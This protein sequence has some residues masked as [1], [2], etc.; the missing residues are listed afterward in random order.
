MNTLL[1]ESEKCDL[2]PRNCRVRRSEGEL[3]YCRSTAD[4]NIAAIC[5]HRGEEPVLSGKDGICNVFFT[6]CNLQCVFCQNYQISRNETNRNGWR[7]KPQEV[8]RKIEEILT[9]GAKTVGFVSPSHCVPQMRTIIHLLKERGNRPVFVMNTNAYDKAGTI[10]GLAD[11]IDVYLPDFKYMVRELADSFSQ[12]PDYPEVAREALR[13]MFRQKG[14][15]IE[16]GPDG[17]IR[18]GLIIRHLVL[19]GQIENSIS[20]LRFIA[21]ELSPCV[22]VSLMAQYHPTPPVS[23]HPLLGRAVTREEYEEVRKELERLGFEKGWLQEPESAGQ[24]L[25][26]FNRPEIFSQPDFD[27][28]P[29]S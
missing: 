12:A 22:H 29:E 2:C 1:A 28:P 26:D 5:L 16:I 7:R 20:C 10:R 15:E 13:E 25:P 19:P 24:Y 27:P 9:G 21:E 4:F 17:I 11:D 18:D 6:H 23:D 14:A 3:G 8:V